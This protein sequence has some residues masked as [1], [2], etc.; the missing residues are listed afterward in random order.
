[1]KGGKDMKKTKFNK[2]IKEHNNNLQELINKH[3]NGDLYFTQNELDII[4]RKR[5]ERTYKRK[6]GVI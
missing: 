5:G 3:I 4:I 1:M 2:L 6:K